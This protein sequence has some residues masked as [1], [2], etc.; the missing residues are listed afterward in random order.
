MTLKVR[1]FFAYFILG[2]LP[3]GYGGPLA[4]PLPRV[5]NGIDV[6]RAEHFSALAGKRV[7]LVTNHTGVAAD[8]TSSIE[9]LR[10]ARDCQLVALFSPEHGIRGSQ[11][12]A[13]GSTIDKKTGIPVYSLYEGNRRPSLEILRRLDVLVYD[14]Q[15]VG[16]RFYTYPTTLAYCM[17]EAARVGIPVFILDRPN[18]LGGLIVEGPMLDAD[19]TS[20]IGYIPLPVRHGMTVGELARYYNRENKI[21][22]DLRVIEMQGWR[23]E[24]YYDQTGQRWI[25]PSPNLRSLLSALLYPGV[26]LLEAS[27]VSVG[28]G[29]ERPFEIIG[30]PWIEPVSLASALNDARVPGVRF[31]PQNYTPTASTHRGAECGGISILLTDRNRFSPLLTGLTLVS[32]LYRQYSDQFAIDKVLRIL[33]NANALKALKSG[34]SP[35]SV[36]RN[37]NLEMDGFR[38]KR[39][40]ALI[41]REYTIPGR[42]NL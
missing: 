2:V 21:G 14:I 13:V 34:E 7:G 8:G 22:T 28:R 25:S 20:F 1:W 12:G 23:R 15:D 3:S 24:F 38:T 27:N 9:L 18:P 6:L 36:L 42:R 37:A 31:V 26:C 10:R 5:L 40:K 16:A 41:Y 17:E 39:E 33:G 19:K 35:E 29:T 11:E 30:A 4:S 32:V